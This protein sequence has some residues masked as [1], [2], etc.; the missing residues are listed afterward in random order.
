MLLATGV[1]PVSPGLSPASNILS[2]SSGGVQD[3]G[4][5]AGS[6]TGLVAILGLCV[7]L[8]W[9]VGVA[10]H[11]AILQ[12]Q[13]DRWSRILHTLSVEDEVESLRREMKDL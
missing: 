11:W 10:V 6:L 2:G 8:S 7:L 9:A 5:W 3:L 12:D 1:A 13:I 4:F